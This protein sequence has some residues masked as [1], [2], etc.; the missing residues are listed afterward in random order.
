MHKLLIMENWN[1]IWKVAKD[2][3]IQQKEPEWKELIDSVDDK[4]VVIEIGSYTGGSS[5]SLAMVAKEVIVIEPNKRWTPNEEN[6]TLF[7]GTSDDQIENVKEYLGKRKATHLIIDG[8]HAKES[9]LKDYNN[10]SKLVKKGGYIWIH[11]I[12]DTEHHRRQN[13]FVADAWAELKNEDSIEI[14]ETEE[15]WGGWGLIVK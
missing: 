6:V 2:N 14:I 1:E 9:V 12:V 3:A 11:D 5:K 10:Y 7:T 4:S 13:C 15:H 8:D